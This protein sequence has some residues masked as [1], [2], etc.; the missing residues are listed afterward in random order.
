VGVAIVILVNVTAV[1]LRR[2]EPEL[3]RPFRIPLYPIPIVIAVAVN[4]ALLAAL[5]YE[6][7]LHSLAGFAFLVA[8]GIVYLMLSRDLRA[9]EA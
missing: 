5:I 7:P 2:K 6:D 4:L 1:A 9:A 3:S 8:V